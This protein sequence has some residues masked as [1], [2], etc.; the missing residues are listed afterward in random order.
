M[1]L[2]WWFVAGAALLLGVSALF[3]GLDEADRSAAEPPLVPVGERIVRDE[4]T[5]VV[6]SAR[7]MDIAPGYS[8]EP[9]AGN[10]YLV[11]TTTVTNNWRV[12]TTSLGDLLHLEWA[13][14]PDAT[15]TVRLI[16]DS[17]LA[18]A[19]P[20][21]PVNVAFVWEIPQGEREVGETARIT[22]SARTL[23]EDGDVTYG[24]YWSDPRPTAYVD[25]IVE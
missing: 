2:F 9:E 20:G 21:F 16:D 10:R 18:Q 24:S 8:L 5:V 22:V 3:G 23:T 1:P 11:V 6:E 17:P 4:F 25:V 13:E 19:N 7:L 14:E 15:R 12:S